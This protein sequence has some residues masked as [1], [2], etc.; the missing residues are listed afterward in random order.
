MENHAATLRA[1][2]GLGVNE[3]DLPAALAGELSPADLQISAETLRAQ[4][5]I[6]ALAGFTQLAEN[7]ARAAELTA[8]PN[9]ELLNMYTAVRPGRSTYAELQTLAEKL[10]QTYHAPLNAQLVREAAA[11]Y[12]QR[13]MLKRNL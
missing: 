5:Q 7:L 9:E 1:A 6:A 11:V 10:E 2:S 13:N 8:V 12:Q 4:A 3:I